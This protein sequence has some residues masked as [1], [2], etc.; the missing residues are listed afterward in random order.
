MSR[1]VQLAIL[2]PGLLSAADWTVPAAARRYTLVRDSGQPEAPVGRVLVWPQSADERSAIVV[3]AGGRPVGTRLVWQSAGEAMEVWFDAAAAGNG[4]RLYV[5]TA[6]APAPWEAP[7][8][9]QLEVRPRPADL[10]ADTAAQI[11][12]QW[13]KAGA[14]QGRGW[15]ER[16]FHGGNPF[17][18]SEEI[19]V[20]YT[21]W[22]DPPAPGAWSIATISDDGSVLLIDGKEIAAWPGWHGADEGTRGQ[23]HGTVQLTSGRHRIDYRVVQGG[24]GFCAAIAWRKPG[25][26][27][28]EWEMVPASAFAGTASWQAQR[29]ETP[30]GP[31][32]SASW[33][34]VEHA[35]P[36]TDAYDPC[37]MR[38]RLEVDA[39][40]GTCTWQ[41]EDGGRY[42]ARVAEHWWLRPGQRRDQPADQQR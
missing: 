28:G 36:G 37:M 31:D 5:G 3:S 12:A 19:L 8:G 25:A 15:A 38:M 41:P 1:L 16:I 32:W 17:G 2:L 23:H 30:R 39:P 29:P 20:R 26:K 13:D 10:P 18:P 35:A 33:R 14:S 42:E 34:I 27:A 11:L 4:A 21:G 22:I 6:L 40:T 24:G 9:L 7:A